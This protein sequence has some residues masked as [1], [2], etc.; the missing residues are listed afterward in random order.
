MRSGRHDLVLLALDYSDPR[1]GDNG[2]PVA[3]LAAGGMMTNEELDALVAQC[4]FMRDDYLEQVTGDATVDGKPCPHCAE[5]KAGADKWQRWIAALA[6]LRERIAALESAPVAEEVEATLTDINDALELALHDNILGME[7]E[8]IEMIAD[9]RDALRAEVAAL[10]QDAARWRTECAMRDAG[11]L[12][13]ML[14]ECGTV[15]EWTAVIDA[16]LAARVGPP[17]VRSS[18]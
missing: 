6:A 10:R 5:A 9:E 16:A 18:R 15:A 1:R 13:S 7:R 2:V 4:E 12:P 17:P 14:L 11:T 8:R 3:A